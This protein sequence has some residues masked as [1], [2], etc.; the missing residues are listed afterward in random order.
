[1]PVA[2]SS[3][4]LRYIYQ[5]LLKCLSN[6]WRSHAAFSTTTCLWATV[7]DHLLFIINFILIWNIGPIP[8]KNEYW[9][10]SDWIYNLRYIYS[11]KAQSN[12]LQR[13]C[14]LR[15]VDC[16]SQH[17][18][19]NSFTYTL[20]FKISNESMHHAHLADIGLISVSDDM[21]GWNISFRS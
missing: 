10:I 21:Q 20:H 12:L 14:P 2:F 16:S 11:D 8:A 18:R 17:S 3:L 6:T 7:N 5:S 9:I 15:S 1:M 13:F 4:M 19:W